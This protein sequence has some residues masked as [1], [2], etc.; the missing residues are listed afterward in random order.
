M[1]KR[2][3]IF[4]LI[5]SVRFLTPDERRLVIAR[6]NEDRGDADVKPFSFKKWAGAGA[7]WRI[8]GYGICESQR[9]EVDP[10]IARAANRTPQASDAPRQ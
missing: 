3:S 1:G 4:Y 7:D 5:G 6:V 10:D 2:Y 8:W 9:E